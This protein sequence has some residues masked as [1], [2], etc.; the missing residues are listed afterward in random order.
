MA[1]DQS[2]RPSFQITHETTPSERLVAGFSSFGLAGLTAANFLIDQLEL[3]ETGF[4]STEALPRIT[5]FE[6]GTPP[7]TLDCSLDPT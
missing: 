2:T 5:P 7:T 3:E 1:V 4:I 6:N